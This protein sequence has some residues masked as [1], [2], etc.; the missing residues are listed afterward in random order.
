MSTGF[1]NG[2]F[3]REPYGEWKWSKQV[4]FDFLPQIYK[5]EDVENDNLLESYSDGLRPQ[6]DGLRHRIREYDSLRDPG[7]V[8]TSY[9]EV[10]VVRLGKNI[11]VRGVV[12]QRGTDGVV[13]VGTK[14]FASNTARFTAQDIGKELTLTDATIASN[15]TPV[16]VSAIIDN[17]AITTTPSLAV[18]A[19]PL[20]WE[21]RAFTPDVD[22]SIF[23]VA[24][25]DVSH[26]APSWLLTDG[27]AI[28]EIFARK[29]LLQHQ[30]DARL[31]TERE[32]ADGQV[33]ASGDI[34][35]ITAA[36]TQRDVG[37]KI[38]VA[39][40]STI[41][42]NTKQEIRRVADPTTA[43]L[44]YVLI[45]GEDST[46]GVGYS[47]KGDVGGL[48]PEIQHRVAGLNTVLSI[49]VV[50]ATVTVNVATNAAGE[51]ISIASDIVIAVNADPAASKILVAQVDGAG[52]GRVARSD[53]L[54]VEGAI[55]TAD[56]GPLFW[57]ILPRP[58]LRTLTRS[59]PNGIVV[60]EG[61]DLVVVS[62]GP[63]SLV[64]SPSFVA[65]AS[66]VGQLLTIR[67]SASGNDGIFEI[68]DVLNPTTI[69]VGA[70][71]VPEAVPLFWEMR[72]PTTQGDR[73]QVRLNAPALIDF[74]ASDFGIDV[75]GHE[76][77]ARQRAGVHNVTQW[78]NRKGNHEGYRILGL[79]SGFDVDVRGLF[80]LSQD[81]YG[82]I[83]L[84]DAFQVGSIDPGRSGH[85]GS[86]N[87]GSPG[88]VRFTAPSALFL[89]SDIGSQIV[90]QNGNPGANDKFYTIDI[91]IDPE[92]VEFRFADPATTPDANNGLLDWQIVRLY[93][94]LA[95]FM[96]SMDDFD[97]DALEDYIDTLDGVNHFRIDKFC[98]ESD[99]LA[100]M[101]TNVLSVV[102][103]TPTNHTVTVAR[104]PFP[105][106]DILAI[107]P[108]PDPAI[109]LPTTYSF[110]DSAGTTYFMETFPTD[111][112]SGTAS[113]EVF[114]TL[115]PAVGA[116]TI[117]YICAPQDFG[118]GYCTASVAHAKITAGTILGESGL[119][120]ENV[121]ERI[122]TKLQT[123]TKP[124]HVTLIP[125]F[126]QTLQANLTLSASGLM[127]IA[128][129]GKMVLSGVGKLA[130]DAQ[131]EQ[132]GE[133]DILGTGTLTADPILTM[134][135]ASSMTGTGT[136][137]ADA[138]VF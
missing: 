47:S 121:L 129:I 75:D 62:S 14:Y 138:E 5:A 84:D 42:N 95:P 133:V 124:A 39:G 96:P 119:A 93:T 25:G 64:A 69:S 73:T 118:C 104:G 38:T 67:G 117:S 82:L 23:E 45:R 55:L 87:S 116:A 111:T 30:E 43:S 4:L 57:A 41:L 122:L 78:I 107:I 29:Q 109:G 32:G 68:D 115:A 137:T 34:F 85:D 44:S 65:D 10:A 76:N 131:I 19:G 120:T 83:P 1:G 18:E 56:L 91:F 17:N 70:P 92:T 52:T 112:G 54:P 36:F 126:Q 9:N 134:V 88:R 15:R 130:V 46:G 108:T 7:L 63:S 103:S 80:R 71:L 127:D 61:T 49:S 13:E 24:A 99:F 40:S 89:A 35:S 8:R 26:V 86:L 33:D 81:L 66:L 132:V 60:R 97:T 59:I 77:E 102:S 113:F 22:Y 136:L 100:T 94:D 51:A 28:L 105:L 20:R 135:A 123:E 106:A 79:L 114:A 90:I 58:Q 37:K 110:V 125:E 12:E 72:S 11:P 16:M 6:F 50:E 21:L 27:S 98:W 128:L 53:V 2:P 31:L 48:T 74:L 101:E 3:G